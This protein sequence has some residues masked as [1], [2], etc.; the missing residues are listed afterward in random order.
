MTEDNQKTAGYIRVSTTDQD[1]ERQY[2]DIKDRFN[3]PREHVYADIQ[4]GDVFTDRKGY[5][6]LMD[7]LDDYEKVVF[8]DITRLGR[9]APEMRDTADTLRE[10]GVTIATVSPLR[11]F[12]PDDDDPMSNLVFDIITRMAEQ[13]LKQIR[14]RTESGVREAK[15]RGK[16]TGRPPRGFKNVGGFLQPNENYDQISHFIYEVNKGRAKKPTARFFNID[17]TSC[18]SILD[19]SREDTGYNWDYTYIGDHDWR[20]ERTLV[21]NGEKDLEPL[22][23]DE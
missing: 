1:P 3:V 12:P 8:E 9:S 20:Q 16:H 4:H 22:G 15:R 7:S 11:E 23:G 5:D 2:Q 6:E 18:Q 21:K 10:N 14:E 19:K 17:P 13:E